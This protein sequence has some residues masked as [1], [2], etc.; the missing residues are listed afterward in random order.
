MTEARYK[1]VK[2]H[3]EKINLTMHYNTLVCLAKGLPWKKRNA[4][5]YASLKNAASRTMFLEQYNEDELKKKIIDFD[6]THGCYSKT[7]PLSI[8]DDRIDKVEKIE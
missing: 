5:F 6:F 7:T 1:F 2:E 3:R 4:T 8:R